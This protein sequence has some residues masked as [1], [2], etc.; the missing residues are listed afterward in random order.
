MLVPA[1]AHP[2]SVGAVAAGQQNLDGEATLEARQPEVQW[3]PTGRSDWQTLLT[4]APVRVGDRVRTGP[5][6]AA[7]LTYFE[8]SVTEVGAD[9][10][11]Q[12]ER[13]GRSPSGGIVV[14]LVQSVGTTLSRVV[15]LVDPQ[16]SFEVQTPA[17]T[18]F[19]RGTTPRVQVAASG[20]TRVANVPDG[21]DSRVFVRGRDPGA[22]LLVLLPGQEADVTPGQPPRLLG[23][24]GSPP[25][26]APAL[27][28]PSLPPP[29]GTSPTLTLPTLTPPRPSPTPDRVPPCRGATDPSG[30]ET[31]P[32]LGTTPPLGTT[33]CSGQTHLTLQGGNCTPPAASTDCASSKRGC[34]TTPA[35]PTGR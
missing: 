28:P 29:S 13:L 16:A 35:R 8:G 19:V 5:G 34:G 24:P 23:A 1:L 27:R 21:T 12:V 4:R 25:P 3:S 30:C 11:L 33:A 32:S 14:E 9:T 15:H 18:V 22:T 10:L 20:Q 6:A 31:T 2:G 26:S 17:A 7:R